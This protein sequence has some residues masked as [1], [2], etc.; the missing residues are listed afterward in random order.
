M[1]T[2]LLLIV[3]VASCLFLVGCGPKHEVVESDPSTVVFEK[4][5]ALSTEGNRSAQYN[6]GLSFF[7]GYGVEQRFLEAVKWFRISAEKGCAEAQCELGKC[8]LRGKG[9][10]YDKS[11]ALFWLKKS[12][13]QGLP[14][15][16][17]CLGWYYDES[18]SSPESQ[19]EAY[20]W[21]LKAALQ[22]NADA[23]YAV[24]RCHER[25]RLGVSIDLNLAAKW[26]SAA[27]VQGQ[28]D[29]QFEMGELL[30]FRTGIAQN[31]ELA[32]SWYRKASDY[33]DIRAQGRLGLCYANGLGVNRD[34]I[35]ALAYFYISGDH[36]NRPDFFEKF[37]DQLSPAEIRDG[38]SRAT[39][40]RASI[41][42]FKL[43]QKL[44][45]IQKVRNQLKLAAG[46]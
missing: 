29:A 15:A 38:E 40:L 37:K 13:D 30:F 18:S 12:A 41:E 6:L 35:E 43:T 22:G 39:E 10:G 33:G 17:M 19:K 44:Q 2:P 27:A 21:Y 25:G 26:Y 31:R 24:G 9:V 1:T 4:L 16:Q 34:L 11:Q 3:S 14:E 7:H 5:K 23:Q 28:V 20:S 8:Y 45:D 46:I 36:K 32:V 42:K